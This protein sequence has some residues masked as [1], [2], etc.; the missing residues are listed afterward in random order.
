MIQVYKYDDDYIFET[1]VI[2]NG[3]GT[4]EEVNLPKNCTTIAPPDGMFKPQFHPELNE[5]W[6]T[7]TED[8][9]L[10]LEPNRE[11]SDLDLLKQQNA[12][13][14]SQLAETQSMAQQQAK[15]YAGLILSLTQKGVV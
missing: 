10:S 3:I 7:A 13:L 11:P 4:D 5:W 12:L 1:P 9:I 15:M 2:I 8:Y 6:E 14:I